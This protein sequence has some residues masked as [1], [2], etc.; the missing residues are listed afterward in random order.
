LNKRMKKAI[1][2]SFRFPETKHKNEFLMQA[3][4]ISAQEEQR[5]KRYPI[6]FRVSAAAAAGVMAL[7]LWSHLG[8]RSKLSEN[9]FRDEPAI[10][11]GTIGNGENQPVTTAIWNGETANVTTEVSAASSL[12]S[13]AAKTT[14]VTAARSAFT[15]LGAGTQRTTAS[16]SDHSSRVTANANSNSNTN[17]NTNTTEHTITNE[18]KT[19]YMNHLGTF[20]SAFVMGGNAIPMASDVEYIVPYTRMYANED[21]IFAD[22]DANKDIVDINDDGIFDMYDCYDIYCYSNFYEVPEQI[23]DKCTAYNVPQNDISDSDAQWLSCKELVRYLLVNEGARSELF[24]ADNYPARSFVN[25]A[26]GDSSSSGFVS[27]LY[28][29]SSYL[30]AGY[31]L[32]SEAYKNDTISFD[33]NADG[34]FDINDYVEYIVYSTNIAKIKQNVPDS[35]LWVR[36]ETTTQR[37]EELSE[38][39]MEITH[40]KWLESYF[41]WCLLENTPFR[42]EYADPAFYKALIPAKYS[43]YYRPERYF[44]EYCEATGIKEYLFTF[45]AQKFNSYFDEYCKDVDAG[46]RSAPDINLDGVIDRKDYEASDIYF[47]DILNGRNASKSELPP[48]IWNNI[49]TNCDFNNNG[50]SG[51]V[52]DIMIT[53]MFVLINSSESGEARSGSSYNYDSNM[54]I[55]IDDD[56]PRSGDV[57]G[58]GEVDMADAVLIM[59]FLADPDKYQLTDSAKFNADVD[60]GCNG[61]N[62]NDASAIQRLLLNL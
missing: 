48:R 41:V 23:K 9:D 5:K 29:E 19:Y 16:R 54:G 61:I 15:A 20:A 35:D 43:K 56:I 12:H 62:S 38:K 55:L 30:M 58:D 60:G 22:I 28:S 6:V 37:C 51:D 50:T 2:D 21:T 46:R 44:E 25:N 11:T 53:Q 39:A 59:Q 13:N 7:G 45:N 49:T 40:D 52:Y 31:P 26:H 4:V 10:V 17:N 47:G 24:N 1:Q 18:E 14:T 57:N 36:P 33:V 32:I 27:Q 34:V 8:S 3:E 42:M